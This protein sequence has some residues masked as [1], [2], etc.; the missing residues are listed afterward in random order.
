LVDAL[1]RRLAAA[2]NT[3]KA[4]R[5]A[6]LSRCA[7]ACFFE[8]DSKTPTLEGARIL[9]EMRKH[10]TLFHSSIG[11]DRNGRIDVENMIRMEGRREIVLWLNNLLELGPVEVARLVEVDNGTS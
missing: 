3:L 6:E 1:K 11:K 10:A 7:K 4:R 2:V 8:D 9:A 5:D